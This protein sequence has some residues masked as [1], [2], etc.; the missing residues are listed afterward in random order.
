[1]AIFM[2]IS[3]AEQLTPPLSLYSI[4][5]TDNAGLNCLHVIFVNVGVDSATCEYACIWCKCPTGERHDMDRPLSLIDTDLGA[6]TIKE[7]EQLSQE[8]KSKKRFNVSRAPLFPTI[9]LTNVVIDNL[10]LFLRV[11]DVLIRLLIDELKR[12]DA[13]TAAKKFTGTFNIS[14]FKHCKGLEEFVGQ[15]GIP[16]YRFY[17]GQTSRQLKIRAL[18]GPE[19]LNVLSS[20]DIWSLLRSLPNSETDQI[21]T[22]WTEL[23]QINKV[24]INFPLLTSL[25]LKSKLEVG[26]E[27][28]LTYTIRKM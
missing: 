23:L 10:H 18:T 12:P 13:I 8:P 20:I 19:K 3:I 17:V 6:R 25:I 9:P 24:L 1:M 16:D 11:F 27:T 15:L 7:N 26:S 21:Q 22:L 2:Y 28:L 5:C 4:S 14:K